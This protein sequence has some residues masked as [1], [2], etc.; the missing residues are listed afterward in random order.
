MGGQACEGRGGAQ[1]ST[2][3]T[4]LVR[5]CPPLLQL[6]TKEWPGCTYTAWRRTLA[7]G[8]SEYKS[9]TLSGAYAGR[10]WSGGED[11]G[12]L[13]ALPPA[14]RVRGTPS[15]CAHMLLPPSPT[16]PLQLLLCPPLLLYPLLPRAAAEDATAEE[17]MDFYMDDAQRAAWD[18]MITGGSAGGCGEVGG[19]VVARRMPA[20]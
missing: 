12:G 4:C 5:A 3:T 18:T 1:H 11:S 10:C 15:C 16:P 9:V 7:T 17:Y 8:R 14:L 13:E 2:L 20:L 19:A 6:M